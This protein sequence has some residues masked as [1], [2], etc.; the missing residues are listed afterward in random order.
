MVD[1]NV[2][3]AA[4]DGATFAP[5]G[6]EDYAPDDQERRYPIVKPAAYTIINDGPENSEP[7]GYAKQILDAA[8]HLNGLVS[9]IDSNNQQELAKVQEIG[10]LQKDKPVWPRLLDM[11][12]GALPKPDRALAEAMAQGP[13]AYRSL[14]QSDPEK[15]ARSKRELV[16]I[17]EMRA[18]YTPEVIG[19][20]SAR[21]NTQKTSTSA[22]PDAM[23]TTPA[24]QEGFLV[25]LTGTTPNSGGSAFIERRVIESLKSAGDR[26]EGMYVPNATF[27][28]C[29]Q[30]KVLM[31]SRRA[32]TGNYNPRGTG[33]RSAASMSD[34][35]ETDPLTGE[36]ILQDYRF[37]IVAAVVLGDKPE[38]PAQ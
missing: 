18:T 23:P 31:G 2:V 33:G 10:N 11:L 21:T 29:E 22:D 36:P 15:Y 27:T 25:T 32:A 20:F 4:E 9:T 12:H 13:E 28:L 5:I 16:V 6:P 35:P 3:Q 34:V 7:L 26:A 8:G 38:K 24:A 17:E 30:M 14:I 1:G 37:E 19:E